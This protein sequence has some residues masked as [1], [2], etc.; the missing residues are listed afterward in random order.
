[1]IRIFLVVILPLLAPFIVYGLY[2][3]WARRQRAAAA[4]EGGAV[5]GEEPVPWLWMALA[6][7]VLMT[8]SLLL[9]GFDR[10]VAPGT[11]VLPPA[12]VDGEVVPAHPA[13]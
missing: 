11:K 7:A 6:G 5:P 10:G 13:D 9:V 12:F 4:G 8:A 3:W 2:V 1:M